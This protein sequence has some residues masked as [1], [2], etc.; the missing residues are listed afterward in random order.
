MIRMGL[1]CYS[2]NNGLGVQTQGLAEHL[3]PSKIMCVDL[4]GLNKTNQYPERF[5]DAQF[6]YGYPTNEDIDIFL[7]DLDCVLVAETPLNYYLFARARELGIKTAQ[8]PNYEFFDYYWY[9]N[10][11]K[12]D[13]IISPSKWH[14]EELKTFTD[15]HGIGLT[16]LHH[17]VDRKKLKFKLRK[18]AKTFLHT[19][20][21]S[22]AYDRNG[23]EIVID[24]AKLLKSNAKIRIHFQGEQGLSHQATNSYEDYLKR[25]GDE[26][27]YPNVKILKY[28]YERYQD[29]YDTG[30]VLLLPR[31]YG[32][33]C[34]PMNE[35][36]SRGMP[37]IMTDISP[38][39]QFLPEH[40]LIPAQKIAEFTP[41]TTI[42]IYDSNPVALAAKI[43]QFAEMNESTMLANNKLADDL[44]DKISWDKMKLKYLKVLSDLCR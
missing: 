21:R 19:A 5:P 37:V 33:N 18:E 25:L 32:G 12:P 23:T 1:V 40:W 29:I 9:P 3:E 38:N 4:S 22:A 13:L 30:D 35:A 43:D 8:I 41:R 20:G 14:Y 24:A 11:P 36:L 17:P 7:E 39:N 28:E 26:S 2:S 31:R 34:L 6:V 10:H 42:D 44:A 16:Y 27:K 15:E